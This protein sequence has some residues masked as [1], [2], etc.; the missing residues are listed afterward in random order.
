MSHVVVIVGGLIALQGLLHHAEVNLT[1][2]IPSAEAINKDLST[3]I[4]VPKPLFIIP[5]HTP[6]FI[7][8]K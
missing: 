8:I 4:R 1:R 6:Q 5:Y 2:E 7:P 3:E